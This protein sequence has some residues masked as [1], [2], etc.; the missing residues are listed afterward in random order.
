MRTLLTAIVVACGA[1]LPLAPV[2]A[3]AKTFG[4]FSVGKEFTLTVKSRISTKTVGTTIKK[5]VPVPTGWPDY[6]VG[7][8]VK[9]TIGKG[10]RLTAKNVSLPFKG[11]SGNQNL[12]GVEPSAT[13]GKD[14]KI[15]KNTKGAPFAGDLFF[16][17]RKF[18]LTGQTTNELSYVFEK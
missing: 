12:Y 2:Q 5:N 16:V 3:T 18:S 13:G 9:F 4:G 1:L 10:G 11:V 17:T 7:T 15:V 14:G 8:K 6:K